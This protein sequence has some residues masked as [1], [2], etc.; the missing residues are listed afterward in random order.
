VRVDLGGLRGQRRRWNIFDAQL[1]LRRRKQIQ[2]PHSETQRGGE[3]NPRKVGHEQ[4][5]GDDVDRIEKHDG[6]YDRYPDQSDVNETETGG[7]QAEEER[8]PSG[9]ENELQGIHRQGQAGTREA[10]LPLGQPPGNRNHY[11]ED[12][13]HR[14]EKPVRRPP[15]RLLQ[16]LIPV[17]GTKQRAR[18]R[19]EETGGD[20][21]SKSDDRS[22]V[23]LIT[24]LYPDG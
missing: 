5:G 18:E 23:Y 11:I 12:G 20:E 13:P 3:R 4:Q 2:A 9:I 6:R 16:S 1:C 10:G 21:A 8:L 19:R 15:G 7:V 22:K 14:G 17:A 24:S